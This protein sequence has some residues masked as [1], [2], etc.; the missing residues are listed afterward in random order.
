VINRGTVREF[1]PDQ[2][3]GVLDAPGVPGGCWVH[4]SAL[5]MPGYRTLAAGQDVSFRSE[6]AD[7][8]GYAFRAVRAWPG[9]GEAPDVVGGN[10]FPGAYTSQLTI[11]FDPPP[12]P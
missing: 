9:H 10:Q 7:Q 11:I 5:A 6:V 8:D 12:E 2:G 4:F 1:H 3:W